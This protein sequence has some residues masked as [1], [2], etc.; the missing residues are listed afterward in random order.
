MIIAMH[1]LEGVVYSELNNKMFC[2]TV[3]SCMLKNILFLFPIFF[4]IKK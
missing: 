1:S 4:L 3:C 2:F